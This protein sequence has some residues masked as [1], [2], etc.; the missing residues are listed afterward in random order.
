M[1]MSGD[2]DDESTGAQSEVT[3]AASSGCDYI[4][5]L[6]MHKL[7][8]ISGSATRPPMII[9]IMNAAYGGHVLSR[10]MTSWKPLL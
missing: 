7:L 3:P 5:S 10:V 2:D 8:W 9:I 1:M 6:H 4:S